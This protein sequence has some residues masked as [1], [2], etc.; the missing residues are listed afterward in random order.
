MNKLRIAIVNDMYMM[1]EHLKRILASTLNCELAWFAYNGQEAVKKCLIDKPDIILMD[2]IMPIMNGV[3]ATKQIMEKCPCAILVVTFS[4]G[5]NASMVFEAMGYGALD[6]VSAPTLNHSG[7]DKKVT[8]LLTKIEIIGKLIGRYSFA[9]YKRET[10]TPKPVIRHL[11]HPYLLLIGA[12]TGGPRAIADII[13]HF[14]G[15]FPLATVIIQHVDEQFA[16]DLARWLGR[17]TALPVQLAYNDCQPTTGIIW[18]AAT[19]DHLVMMPNGLMKYQKSPEDNPYRPSVDVFFSSVAK[20]WDSHGVAVLLTGMGSDGAEGLRQLHEEK[21]ITIAQ[22]EE[23][24]V[25]FGMPKA[26]IKINAASKVLPISQIG[27]AIMSYANMRQ[28]HV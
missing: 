14:P 15:D 21:W 5:V 28:D 4:V 7:E 13:S 8:D 3:E 19:N 18:I 1:V 24:C 17:Q 27:Q 23:S 26:A 9:T 16:P 10:I 6:A 22:D 25:V 2:L 12:S 20:N 11:R